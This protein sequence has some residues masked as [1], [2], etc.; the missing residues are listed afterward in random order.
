MRRWVKYLLA[1]LAWGWMTID[2]IFHNT[3][4]QWYGLWWMFSAICGLLCY[5]IAEGILYFVLNP[6]MYPYTLKKYPGCT[7]MSIIFIVS[8]ILAVYQF[9]SGQAFGVY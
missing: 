4:P 8:F 7:I 1:T 9:V 6:I 5:G 2:L 3:M